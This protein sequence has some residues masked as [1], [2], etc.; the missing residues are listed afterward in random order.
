MSVVIVRYGELALK[1]HSIRRFFTKQLISNIQDAMMRDGI[2]GL[3]EEERGRIYV[4][5]GDRRALSTISR[6]FGIVSVSWAEE[7]DADKDHI[8]E[9]AVDI[10]GCRKGSFAVRA[11]RTGN[12]EYT[13]QEL[14]AYVGE[15]I[16]ERCPDLKVNLKN[17]ENEVHI[18]VRNNRAFVFS[19]KTRAVGGM[20]MGT[21]GDIRAPL[22]D[23][24][25]LLA[26]WMMLKRG[27]RVY[28]HH[29]NENILETATYW[30]ALLS[31]K[32]KYLAE[33]TGRDDE[34]LKKSDIPV[35]CPLIGL[36]D[37]EIEERLKVVFS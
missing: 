30:G 2:E 1:S 16:L 9:L 20:P 37:K 17:P 11:T 22:R 12:H 13:S 23:E 3:I 33:V 21:Q 26:V 24:R 4:Q 28:V 25:D 7:T 18:E 34:C 36:T 6:V 15:K 19:G 32:R 10:F 5:T 8:S 27:C 14:A 29:V 35:F 31:V